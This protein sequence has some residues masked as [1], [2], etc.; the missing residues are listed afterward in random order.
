MVD[1]RERRLAKNETLFRDVNDKIEEIA[2]AHGSDEHEYEFM[3][4]CSNIDCNLRVRLTLGAYEQARSDPTVFLAAPGHELPEI[5]DV[6][7]RCD[8]YQL[9][10]KFGEAAELAEER[11]PRHQ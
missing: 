10:R 11:D 6:I 8:E 2:V 9:V 3:C 7:F 1:E 5:E 4:E